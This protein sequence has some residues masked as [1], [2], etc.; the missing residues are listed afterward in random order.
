MPNMK[1]SHP[2]FDYPVM[3]KRNSGPS[4]PYGTLPAQGVPSPFWYMP[5]QSGTPLAVRALRTAFQQAA[6]PVQRRVT[7]GR[8]PFDRFRG[9]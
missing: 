9:W 6:R 5:R 3:P 2:L 8:H 7:R 4:Q 1:R